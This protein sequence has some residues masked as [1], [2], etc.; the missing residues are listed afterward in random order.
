MGGNAATLEE[1]LF[2]LSL[3]DLDFDSLV[4]LLLMTLPVIGIGFDGGG[5]EGVDKGGLAQARLTSDLEDNTSVKSGCEEA[6]KWGERASGR[7]TCSRG[8]EERQRGKHTMMVKLA[9][10][11]ATILC[12]WLGRLAMPMGE[13][14][15]GAGG[16]MAEEISSKEGIES[17]AGYPAQRRRRR[18]SRRHSIEMSAAALRGEAK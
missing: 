3:G 1:L 17:D 9:P 18:G 10:R 4:H 16:A 13:A 11:L 8:S 7:K 2:E 14:L 6:A 15:S 5:E 12:R